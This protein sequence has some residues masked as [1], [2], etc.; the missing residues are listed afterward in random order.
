MKRCIIGDG[1][2][3]KYLTNSMNLFSNNKTFFLQS[4]SRCA[5]SG[6]VNRKEDTNSTN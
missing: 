1:L 5:I 2:A 6:I 3:G 4:G